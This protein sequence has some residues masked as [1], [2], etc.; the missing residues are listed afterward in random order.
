[1]SD[2]DLAS[3]PLSFGCSTDAPR[4]LKNPDYSIAARGVNPL[5]GLLAM[6]PEC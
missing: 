1:M 4:A 2:S 6:G 5:L 3:L